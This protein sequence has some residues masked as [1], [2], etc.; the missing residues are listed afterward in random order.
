MV[1]G[2]GYN[3]LFRGR[4]AGARIDGDVRVSDGDSARTLPWRA[5]R[6]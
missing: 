3:L 2:K 5:I 4:I 6:P 1:G